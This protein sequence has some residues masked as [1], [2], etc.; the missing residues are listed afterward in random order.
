MELA[1]IF[2]RECESLDGVVEVVNLRELKLGHC[3]GCWSGDNASC[4]YPCVIHDD[5]NPVFESMIHADG[6]V[7]VSGVYWFG[8]TSL[9][10]LLI[11]RMTCL[12]NNGCQKSLLDGKPCAVI[13]SSVEEGNV[14]AAAPLLAACLFLGLHILPYGMIYGNA[15]EKKDFQNG[16]GP[17]FARR[18][19]R[20]MARMIDLLKRGK[21]DWWDNR[22]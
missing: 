10:K 2:K 15:K 18:A 22:P 11:D 5:L 16:W 9:L 1:R 7:F 8:V 19:G 4:K 13:T 21:V 14:L 3:L 20:N 17:D 6:I 12:W